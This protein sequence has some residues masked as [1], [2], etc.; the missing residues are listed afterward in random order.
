MSQIGKFLNLHPHMQSWAIYNENGPYTTNYKIGDLSPAQYGGLSYM[1]LDEKGGDIYIIQT[2][3]F[4]RCAIW[5]PIDNDSNI[6][7]ERSYSNGDNNGSGGGSL[8]PGTGK[9]LNLHPH[10]QSWAVYNENGPYTTANAIGS[11]APAQ[12]GG[13]SYEILAEKGGDIYIIQTE[14]F[15]RCAIWA[16]RDNDSSITSTPQYTN[17]S[18][19]G[20]GSTGGTGKY[21]NLHPHMQSWAVY[22]ENG[23]YTTDYKI[24][25]LAPAQFG[26]L[27]YAILAEKGGDIYII[28]TESFGRCAIWAPRDND[29]SITSTPQ[30]TNG[31]SSGGGSTG[32][33]GKY[34]NLHPHMQSW[35]VYNENGPYTTSYKIG[36][37]APAQY[38]GLS[39]LILEEKGG[40]IY[41]IQ[42]EKF[43]RCAIWAPR[44]NDSSIT[45]TP[46]Y[47]NGNSS[48]NG[49]TGN[50]GGE[51]P[52][53]LKVFIDPGHGGYDPGA[54]GNGFQEKAIVLSIAKKLGIILNSYGISVKYSRENDTFI[55]LED[56]SQMANNWGANLFVSIH[57]NSASPSVRG[58]ECY[59][60]PSADSKT[61]QL[62][63]NVAKS[64]SSR[65]G[66]PNRGHKEEIWRVLMLSN[67]PSIL[68]ETAFISNYSDAILLANN[69]Y[70]FANSI[71]TQI[72]NYLG[73]SDE[74]SPK[75]RKID[76][77]LFH[78]LT[79]SAYNLQ[80]KVKPSHKETLLSYKNLDLTL[81]AELIQDEPALPLSSENAKKISN[82]SNPSDIFDGTTGVLLDMLPASVTAEVESTIK[83][84]EKYEFS[85][86]KVSFSLVN[87]TL[88]ITAVELSTILN[89]P[90]NVRVKETLAIEGTLDF[91]KLVGGGLALATF[92]LI[93]TLLDPVPGDE[94][95]AA[96]NFFI[97]IFDE[98][99]AA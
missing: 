59:T 34:L 18:S 13:L 8:I 93:I 87:K 46:Q 88:T 9:Y 23:P 72:L 62:S 77:G 63:A 90:A 26:G 84:I 19:S 73:I 50:G 60:K 28:Q 30:Y 43:G 75:E 85:A 53:G 32:G 71:A 51:I 98:L 2:E 45:S 64:I 76:K 1:I 58:T 89:Y 55:E 29:S 5:A 14:S 17:G 27:S 57:A 47:T 94:L 33:T 36:D 74:T 99:I 79:K 20:G 67:M 78:L 7:Y 41:I 21:L 97:A 39:Y 35:A 38:G 92:I 54:V 12:F 6:T 86:G 40:D 44:D 49:D 82:M 65:F 66:I 61:K 15:G 56:R 16:P 3:S 91:D 96:I 69:E 70:S 52:G 4:G 48:G 31:S 81:S 68:V 95:V 11:L 10:M 83:W 80:A 24:G 37:I 22:N 25:S 42:T